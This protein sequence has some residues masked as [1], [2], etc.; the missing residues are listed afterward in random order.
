MCGVIT[1]MNAISVYHGL[2]S[3][4][5][6]KNM[7]HLQIPLNTSTGRLCHNHGSEQIRSR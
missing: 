1:I 3:T 5:V 6:L 7:I 4:K 2:L